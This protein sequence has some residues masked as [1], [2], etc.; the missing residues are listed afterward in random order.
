MSVC[1]GQ[2]VFGLVAL[3]T[4]AVRALKWRGGGGESKN[5]GLKGSN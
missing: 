5:I 3:E 1:A 4:V 2:A